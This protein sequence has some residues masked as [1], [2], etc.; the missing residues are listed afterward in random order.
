MELD[1][2]VINKV[3]ENLENPDPKTCKLMSTENGHMGISNDNGDGEPGEYNEIIKLYKISSIKDVLLKVV[4]TTD[5]YGDA[6]RITSIQ[7]VKPIKKEI[8]TYEKI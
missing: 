5:S 6:R 7:F 8:T 3:L 1:L 4:Y 2:K